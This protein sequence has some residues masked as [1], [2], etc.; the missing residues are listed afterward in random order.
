MNLEMRTSH[1]QVWKPLKSIARDET[2]R[3]YVLKTAPNIEGVALA[4]VKGL[5]T[6]SVSSL[7][8]H[9]KH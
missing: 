8:F 9:W 6:D 2:E 5:I 7:L 4:Y 1:G 3:N